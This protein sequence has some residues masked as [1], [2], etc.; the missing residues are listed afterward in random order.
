VT[1]AGALSD[2]FLIDH[3]LHITHVQNA[4]SPAVT[5]SLVPARMVIDQVAGQYDRL[6]R[7]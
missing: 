3:R 4:P 2:D 6:A 7:R 1:R 5:S